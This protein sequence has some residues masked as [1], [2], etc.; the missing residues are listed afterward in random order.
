MDLYLLQEK[1][2]LESDEKAFKEL[3]YHFYNKLFHFAYAFIK[4][5]QVAE[6]ITE[7]VFIKVWRNRHHLIEIKNIKVYLY[8]ATKNSSLNYLAKKAHEISSAPYDDIAIDVVEY[9]ASPEQI[10]ISS[11]MFRKLNKA[12]DELP[13]RCKIIF[14]LIRED[15]LK[16]KEVSEILSLSVNTIDVQMAIAVKKIA[17]AISLDF[18]NLSLLENIIAKKSR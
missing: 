6:E 4:S 2:A 14:K 17:H 16:Y 1:I 11:E 12:I 13:P 10:M 5:K 18:K 8:T 7:D 15:G 9:E 3:Y